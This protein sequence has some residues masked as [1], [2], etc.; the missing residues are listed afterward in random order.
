MLWF[1]KVNYLH[2]HLTDDQ[3]ISWPS[4]AFPKLQSENAGWTW[5]DFEALEAY[6]QARGV[7]IIPE[8]DV[9]GHSGILR[10]EYP[11]VFGENPTELA[12][13]MEAQR[14]V[15]TL[16]GEFLSVFKSTPYVHVGGD[17]AYGVPQDIQRNFLNRLNKF[18]RSKGKTMVVWEG[19]TL[20]QGPNKVSTDVLHINWRTI[21]FPAQEML[22]AG[23][24]VVN[25]AWDPMYVVDHYPKTMFTAVDLERCFGWI[26]QRFAHVN[27]E[28]PTFAA[29]H[30]T[31]TDRGIVGFCMPYWEG[32]PENLLPLCLPRLAAVAAGAWNRRAE[33]EFRGLSEAVPNQHR[34]PA[35]DL[36]FRP[37]PNAFRGQGKPARQPSISGPSARL[38]RQLSTALRPRPLDQ[39]N[40]R[41]LRPLPGFPH[42]TGPFGNHPRA[43]RTCPGGPDRGA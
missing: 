17:E 43:D 3:I 15:E 41:P 33:R 19:P 5:E 36:W 1:Y 4:R 40:P 13:S 11:E 34:A 22:D 21:D 24:Q 29:P 27:H 23:Y 20:G 18:V 16:I 37:A 35:N 31:N 32:R 2:L 25:A 42:P 9:P 14:G 26:P 12:S 28:L 30:A 39:W 10:R 8:I 6:S 7:T 38:N